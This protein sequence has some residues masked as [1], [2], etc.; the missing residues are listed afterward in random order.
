MRILGIWELRAFVDGKS[1]IFFQNHKIDK[2]AVD[3][4]PHNNN[5]NHQAGR[6]QARMT[7]PSGSRCLMKLK[8]NKGDKSKVDIFWIESQ[9][10]L[11]LYSA[12]RQ[13]YIASL[14][15]Y[16]PKFSDFHFDKEK[17]KNIFSRSKKSKKF[18]EEIFLS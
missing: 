11:P 18:Q 17:N 14:Y 6:S 3:D 1:V 2:N 7:S 15:L 16:L 4:N 8:S 9:I 5:I 10:L 12:N 13:R